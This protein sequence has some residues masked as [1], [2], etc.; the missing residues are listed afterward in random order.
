M[1]GDWRKQHN[2]EVRNFYSSPSEIRMMKSR[3]I[4]VMHVARLGERRNT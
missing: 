4:R 1:T 3:R 2:E